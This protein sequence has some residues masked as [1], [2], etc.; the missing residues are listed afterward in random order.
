M[1]SNS[2]VKVP[3][4]LLSELYSLH[5]LKLHNKSAE[6]KSG[7]DFGEVLRVSFFVLLG[8]CVFYFFHSFV[9]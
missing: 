9:S 7:A 2:S 5:L 8:F 6:N 4:L 1:I 3:H